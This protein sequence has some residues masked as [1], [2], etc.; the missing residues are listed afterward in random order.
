M[1]VNVTG[2]VAQ[3]VFPGFAP[4]EACGIVSGTTVINASPVAGFTHPF[5]SQTLIS[6]YVKAPGISVG[7]L[8][9]TLLLPD[10]MMFWI[11]PLLIVY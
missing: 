11:A 8:S 6:R 10:V 3:M 2:V 5:A 4:M 1:A 7:A 9:V